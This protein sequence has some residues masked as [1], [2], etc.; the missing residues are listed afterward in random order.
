MRVSCKSGDFGSLTASSIRNIWKVWA[1]GIFPGR[2]IIRCW[3]KELAGGDRGKFEEAIAP[4]E[5][6]PCGGRGDRGRK[7]ETI[8]PRKRVPCEVR[9][10][11]GRKRGN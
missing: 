4:R 9:G 6:V 8:T 1:E 11:R 3:R 7:Q 2:N 5:R 10:D